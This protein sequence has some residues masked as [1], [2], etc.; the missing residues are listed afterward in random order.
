MLQIQTILLLSTFSDNQVEA[1]TSHQQ[2]G[3]CDVVF[4][5]EH[6]GGSDSGQLIG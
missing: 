4:I 2:G 3:R 5:W 6:A 1:G